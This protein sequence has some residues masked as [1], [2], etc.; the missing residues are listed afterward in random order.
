MLMNQSFQDFYAIFRIKLLHQMETFFHHPLTPYS[1]LSGGKQL[2]SLLFFSAN[3]QTEENIRT[4]FLI[5]LVHAASL[6]HD[7]I[8]DESPLRRGKSTLFQD[9]GVPKTA[10]IGYFL[11]AYLQQ[12]L[13]TQSHLFYQECFHTLESMCRG[14]IQELHWACSDDYSIPGYLETIGLKTASLFRLTSGWIN[15]GFNLEEA[16]FGYTFGE[17]FQII[18]DIRD[19]CLHETITGK[20]YQ[21]DAIQKVMTLPV[22]FSK[23]KTRQSVDQL[24]LNK[25]CEFGKQRLID[26]KSCFPERNRLKNQLLLS[27]KEL[28]CQIDTNTGCNNTLPSWSQNEE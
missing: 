4:A 20:P 26:A 17:V 3:E 24:S 8:V 27:L 5:E 25:A 28:S 19:F 10:S 2:R 18:D 6:V 13:L 12:Q 11:L 21:Q 1:I 14:Q 22:F 9:L 7:D 23:L 16:Q 15:S